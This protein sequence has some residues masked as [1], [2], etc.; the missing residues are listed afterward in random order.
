MHIRN[1][2]DNPLHLPTL[3]VIVEPGDTTE[4]VGSDAQNLLTQEET[5]GRAD[6]SSDDLD[7]LDKDALL[8]LAEASGVEVS[9]RWGEKRIRTVLRE[10]GITTTNTEASASNPEGD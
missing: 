6:A 2:T 1:E 5:W 4:V 3:G 9:T 10:A 7:D 8:A